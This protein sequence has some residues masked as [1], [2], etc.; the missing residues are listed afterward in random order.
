M[1][2]EMSGTLIQEGYF[3]GIKRYGYWYFD[4]DNK[5]IEKSVWAG[6][7]KNSISW[8]ELESLFKGQSITKINPLRFF[9]SLSRLTIQI[10]PTSTTL[11]FKPHKSLDSNLKYI[12]P[13]II[14]NLKPKSLLQLLFKSLIRIIKTFK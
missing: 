14:D 13:N 5:R 2:D 8:T 1:K 9:K 3:L 12:S 11:S 4:K 7:K 10:R 6:V